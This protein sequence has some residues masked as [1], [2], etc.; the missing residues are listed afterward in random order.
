[1]GVLLNADADYLSRSGGPAATGLTAYT[2]WC[3]HRRTSGLGYAGVTDGAIFAQEGNA[4]RANILRFDNTFGDGSQDGPRLALIDN[5]GT[6]RFAVG[7]DHPAF[8]TWHFY[9]VTFSGAAGAVTANAYYSALGSSTWFAQSRLM[10]TEDSITA[11]TLLFGR[12]LAGSANA[13]QGDYAYCGARA[14]AMSETD[15]K[16]IKTRSATAAGDWGYWILP[17]AATLTDSSGNSRTLTANGTVTDGATPTFPSATTRGQPFVG[18]AF[19]GGRTLTGIIH[20]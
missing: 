8:D 11:Q 20:A 7:D 19:N 3:W 2:Q 5:G 4:G 15:A 17:D 18:T 10:S 13:S 6:T 9:I 14:E 1:M 16:A 12:A